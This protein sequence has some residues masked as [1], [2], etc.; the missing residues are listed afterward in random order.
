MKGYYSWQDKIFVWV[1]LN[2][3]LCIGKEKYGNCC[4]KVCF[5]FLCLNRYK[6]IMAVWID[7]VVLCIFKNFLGWVW[8]VSWYERSTTFATFCE[9]RRKF[10]NWLCW[11]SYGNIQNKHSWPS[12]VS[13]F[14]MHWFQF[15]IHSFLVRNISE[16]KLNKRLYFC[17]MIFI[18]W[19][20]LIIHKQFH[21]SFMFATSKFK[22]DQPF[23]KTLINIFL[24]TD[25]WMCTKSIQIFSTTKQIKIYQLSCGR[26]I[27]SPRLK[28]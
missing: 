13:C 18:L 15:L 3:F 22:I 16:H 17:V 19:S 24:M 6:F 10:S 28:M 9:N 20:N 25:T 23:F 26:N 2:F 1:Y 7:I 14:Q 5:N 12:E 4:L 27:P 8:V 21:S 11:Q